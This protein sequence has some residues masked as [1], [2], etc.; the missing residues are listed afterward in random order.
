MNINRDTAFKLWDKQF[1]KIN[2][3][4]DF[5]GRRITKGA[6]GNNN[7]RYCWN[8]D[9]IKP[10][11]QKGKSTEKNLI[12]C[13]VTTNS[14]KGSNFPEFT[15]NSKNFQVVSDNGNYR[16]VRLLPPL[17]P[18][19]E[20][21]PEELKEK[22]DANLMELRKLREE[23]ESDN[24]K[25]NH[26]EE[27]LKDIGETDAP[28]HDINFK[29][30]KEGIDFWYASQRITCEKELCYA[31]VSISSHINTFGNHHKT[32]YTFLSE[33]F[34]G[35]PVY[36]SDEHYIKENEEHKYDFTIINSEST[37]TAEE[38]KE[39]CILLNSY[40]MF[41]RGKYNWDISIYCTENKYDTKMDMYSD[42]TNTILAETPDIKEYL[43]IEM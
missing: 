29:D 34:D 3:A 16:I 2:E 41:F 43:K 4:I 33:L 11:S 38:F 27:S 35:L 1:G 30:F 42:I 23:Y 5:A 13:H 15:A 37:Y 12:C 14:E 17:V 20:F 22:R 32:M 19:Y 31:K 24:L 10:K 6:Y 25:E 9:H 21:T 36:I 28:S 18:K 8:I 40:A 7:S 39:K 26:N